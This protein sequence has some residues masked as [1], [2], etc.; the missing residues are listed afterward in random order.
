MRTRRGRGRQSEALDE[1]F[2]PM[3]GAGQIPAGEDPRLSFLR[4]N[5][6]Y[7]GKAT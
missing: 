3:L 5:S 4:P 7:I 6:K 1:M 2:G